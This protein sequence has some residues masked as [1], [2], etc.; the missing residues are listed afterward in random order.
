MARKITE[1]ASYGLFSVIS[2]TAYSIPAVPFAAIIT[3][4]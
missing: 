3:G 4:H 2:F 1:K